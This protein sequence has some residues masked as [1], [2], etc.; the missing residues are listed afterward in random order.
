M[1]LFEKKWKK[2]LITENIDEV[3]EKIV[4]KDPT[5]K[6]VLDH[7]RSAIEQVVT[8]P[9]LAGQYLKWAYQQVVDP[10]K[11]S[12]IVVDGNMSKED[13]LIEAIRLFEANK[14]R[15][16]GSKNIYDYDW[17]GVRTALGTVEQS[18]REKKRQTTNSSA[19]ILYESNR[20]S[21][22]HVKTKEASCQYGAGTKWCTAAEKDNM[23]DSYNHASNLVII[24]SKK[25]PVD[26]FQLGIDKKTG[27]VEDAMDSSDSPINIAKL[28]E[29]FG[30]AETKKILAS[31]PFIK[32]E[33]NRILF[34]ERWFSKQHTVANAVTK[35][36]EWTKALNQNYGI[37]IDRLDFRHNDKELFWS[38]K[39]HVSENLPFQFRVTYNISP[40]RS[41]ETFDKLFF[42][43]RSGFYDTLKFGLKSFSLNNEG[44]SLEDIGCKKCHRRNYY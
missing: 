1:K 5:R 3:Y 18:N 33:N 36:S 26:K 15:I 17:K 28:V 2:F 24:A 19:D 21:V 7:F 38:I 39:K 13:M 20:V 10:K 35:L 32:D 9:N 37:F 8:N 43:K 40:I 25:N 29:T 14:S 30:T 4:R 34:F 22:I 31:I 12:E 23:F 44:I 16:S 42:L 6:T 27:A 11:Y 41:Q